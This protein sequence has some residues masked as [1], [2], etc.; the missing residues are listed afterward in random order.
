MKQLAMKGVVNFED[1][2]VLSWPEE[3]FNLMF[4]N[5]KTDAQKTALMAD[6]IQLHLIED[7]IVYRVSRISK[8]GLTFARV[9]SV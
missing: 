7:V 4:E 9:R 8:R 1:G 6:A 3:F 5:S 2:S